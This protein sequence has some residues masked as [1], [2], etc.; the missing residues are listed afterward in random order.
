MSGL[1]AVEV[2]DMAEVGRLVVALAASGCKLVVVAGMFVAVE[3]RR[4]GS[5]VAVG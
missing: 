5:A 3:E 2:V 1:K 4:T